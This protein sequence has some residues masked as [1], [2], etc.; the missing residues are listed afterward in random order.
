MTDAI[1]DLEETLRAHGVKCFSIR[2]LP[3][4]FKVNFR[5]DENT[6]QEGKPAKTLRGAFE[7]NGFLIGPPPVSGDDE[8]EDLLG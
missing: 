1:A 8:F 3:K 7:S 5:L 6:W 4:G 2:P